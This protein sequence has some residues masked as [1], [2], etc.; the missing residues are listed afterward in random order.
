MAFSAYATVEDIRAY[1]PTAI[2]DLWEHDET[3]AR[4]SLVRAA[5]KINERISGL[6]RFSVVPIAVEDDGGYA[7]ILIELNVY[8]ALWI[9][10][11]GIYAG[12][13]FEE[14]WA[15]IRIRLGQIWKG[16]E[17]GTFSFGSEPEAASSGS[18]AIYTRRSSP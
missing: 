4:D 6:D 2:D 16:V 15:W 8:E 12:E 9:R 17:D 5:K 13:A 7:E 1:V 11:S 10:V 14:T 3:Q 18:V